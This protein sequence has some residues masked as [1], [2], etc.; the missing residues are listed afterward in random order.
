MECVALKLLQTFPIPFFDYKEN[1][2]HFKSNLSQL[3]IFWKIVIIFFGSA[4]YESLRRDS[5]GDSSYIITVRKECF[6]IA[7]KF[8][9]QEI[10]N[11]GRHKT[12][13]RLRPG[14]EQIGGYK[15]KNHALDFLNDITEPVRTLCNNLRYYRP[16]YQEYSICIPYKR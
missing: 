13:R 6:E 15:E 11:D 7:R 4:R 16:R 5:D 9:E 12:F 10:K 2:S 8:W 14:G 3:T 1:I